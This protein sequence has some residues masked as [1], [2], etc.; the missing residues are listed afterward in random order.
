MRTHTLSL[1]LWSQHLPLMRTH[2]LSLSLWSQHLPL[3]RTHT[4][5]LSLWSQHLPLM[6]T[7]TL[8]LSLWSQ[9]LP[10]TPRADTLSPCL[11]ILSAPAGQYTPAQRAQESGALLSQARY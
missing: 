1:S 4:L 9:H 6:R 3:M 8:S 7:H 5:S 2:T 11:S 10:L